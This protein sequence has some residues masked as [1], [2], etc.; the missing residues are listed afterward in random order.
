MRIHLSLGLFVSTLVGL[1]TPLTAQAAEAMCVGPEGDCT[2]SNVPE[3][4]LI[5][6][7][8]SGLGGGFFGGNQWAGLSD[9]DLEPI[10]DAELLAFC[11]GAPPFPGLECMGMNGTCTISNNPIDWIEC[12]CD[13]GSGFGGGGGNQWA[14]LSD[15]DLLLICED[16]A[17]MGCMG[18]PPPPP[19]LVCQNADGICEI[20]NFPEDNLFCECADGSAGGI[21]GGNNWAGLSDADLLMVCDDELVQFCSGGL[22]PATT[23]TDGPDTEGGESSTSDD[24]GATDTSTTS[25][26]DATSTTTTSATGSPDTGDDDTDPPGTSEEGGSGAASTGV[27]S[28]GSTS[29]AATTGGS[30]GAD[31]GADGGGDGGGGCSVAPR[32]NAG[33]WGLMLLGLAGLGWRRRRRAA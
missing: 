5:C 22:P 11:G 33:G 30:G 9:T 3:D 23:T 31:G 10:C 18:G 16:Q 2:V 14:G 17:N 27:S 32:S 25:G 15:A 13:D 6:N 1:A 12:A 19:G 4:N 7:C 8:A 28:N 24:P 26:D 20:S 21:G 29:V